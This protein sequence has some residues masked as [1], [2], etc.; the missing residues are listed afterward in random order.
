MLP[1]I[2]N[3]KWLRMKR[4]SQRIRTWVSEWI[5]DLLLIPINSTFIIIVYNIHHGCL[6]QLESFNS[7]ISNYSSAKNQRITKELVHLR[8]STVFFNGPSTYGMD[9]NYS[10]KSFIVQISRGYNVKWTLL[11]LCWSSYVTVIN[12]VKRTNILIVFHIQTC[13][14]FSYEISSLM[15][16]LRIM[17]EPGNHHN[18][19]CRE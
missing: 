3:M 10:M 1:Q 2:C 6:I 17:K 7:W 11:T 9:I 19:I 16:S 18:L 5:P 15:C 12:S 14:K 13:W 4:V 8:K